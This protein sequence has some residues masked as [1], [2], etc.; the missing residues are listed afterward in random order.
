MIDTYLNVKEGFSILKCKLEAEDQPLVLPPFLN[1]V[2][3]VTKDQGYKSKYLAKKDW[4]IPD[5]D[6]KVVTVRKNSFTV[7]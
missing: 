7:D 4:Y 1:T 6:E 2:R 3:D 5:G